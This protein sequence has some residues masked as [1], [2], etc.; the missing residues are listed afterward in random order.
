MVNASHF[1]LSVPETKPL[2][3]RALVVV[4]ANT[5]YFAQGCMTNKTR[6]KYKKMTIPTW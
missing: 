2:I 5:I 4:C 3:S 6:E 1:A